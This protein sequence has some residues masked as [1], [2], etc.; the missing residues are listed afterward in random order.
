M[1]A[2]I[3]YD[4]FAAVND[5]DNVTDALNA[6]NSPSTLNP[7]ATMAD[8]GGGGG[9]SVGE[10]LWT[11][12]VVDTRSVAGAMLPV[13]A[14][15]YPV[16][17]AVVDGTSREITIVGTY[18][19]IPAGAT[20][21]QLQVVAGGITLT[22]P[23]D[24]IGNPARGGDTYI[25]KIMLNFRAG[26]QAHMMVNVLR[27]AG[28]GAPLTQAYAQ[29]IALGTWDKTIANGV[30]LNWQIV[31]N[32]LGPAPPAPDHILTIKQVKSILS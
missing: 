2:D 7:I 31:T 15:A 26:N 6:A 25:I 4:P 5:P 20:T 16:N 9:G 8:V 11:A 17:A 32:P 30:I 22:L 12:D 14:L 21:T 3:Q 19:K 23:V 28:I 29:T 24:N 27:S 18:T 10:I 13:F 1:G